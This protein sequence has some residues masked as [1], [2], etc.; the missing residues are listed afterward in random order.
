MRKITKNAE[1]VELTRWKRTHIQRTY[2]LLDAQT[3]RAIRRDCIT[4]QKGLCAFCCCSIDI[5]HAHNAHIQDKHT[6]PQLS[7][8]WSNITA[9][10]C[11][12]N[13]CGFIQE[14]NSLPL[15][16]LMPECE[17]EFKFYI[18]GRIKPLTERAAQ[19]CTVLNLDS[20]EQ[21]Q[22][23]KQAIR[24]L[25]DSAGFYP[26]EDIQEWDQELIMAFIAECSK[27]TDGVLAPFAPVLI[28]I[29]RQFC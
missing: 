22:K 18:S 15:T 2:N 24:A 7:L 23:R 27:E 19:T 1:P 8:D 12:Q 14:R 17:Y 6:F 9:S 3:R 20:V 16:P 10:C 21:R 25:T 5:D 13:S 4:E 26:I 11:N 28:N 29:A